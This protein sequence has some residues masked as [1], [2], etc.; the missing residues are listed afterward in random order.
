[1]KTEDEILKGMLE[2]YKQQI[3]IETIREICKTLN[4]SVPFNCSNDVQHGFYCA[5]MRVK[6]I[7]CETCIYYGRMFDAPETVKKDCLWEWAREESE[8]VEPPCMRGKE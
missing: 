8:P 3:R 4:E 7:E 1:M 6:Q 2:E 5:I